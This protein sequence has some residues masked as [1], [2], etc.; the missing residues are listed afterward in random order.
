MS[1]SFIISEATEKSTGAPMDIL[2]WGQ[3]KLSPADY[4]RLVQA[5]ARQDN[6]VN[7]AGGVFEEYHETVFSNILQKNIL[8]VIGSKITFPSGPPTN[9]PEWES[10]DIMFS[11]DPDISYNRAIQE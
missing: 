4:D 11:Q 1:T 9:D 6:I 7:N 2:T 8:V 10:F 3:Q 5:Q